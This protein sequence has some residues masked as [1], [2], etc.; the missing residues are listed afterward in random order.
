MELHSFHSSK[1]TSCV[2]VGAMIS[3]KMEW[4]RGQYGMRIRLTCD[5]FKYELSERFNKDV[6]DYD[7]DIIKYTGVFFVYRGKEKC[8]KYM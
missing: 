2:L 5:S 8:G 6:K 4:V 7:F 1:L 3:K